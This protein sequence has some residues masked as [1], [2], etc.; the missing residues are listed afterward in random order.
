MAAVVTTWTSHGLSVNVLCTLCL[1]KFRVRIFKLQFHQEAYGVRLRYSCWCHIL[2]KRWINLAFKRYVFTSW[3][4][5]CE[6]LIWAICNFTIPAEAS[7]LKHLVFKSLP[8]QKLLLHAPRIQHCP[9]WF[10]RKAYVL[11]SEPTLVCWHAT[12]HWWA[13]RN[14]QIIVLHLSTVLQAPV[15]FPECQSCSTCAVFAWH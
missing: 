12:P 11:P 13:C 6:C 3:F 8:L 4:Q 5:F 10:N 14:M 15:Q 7:N 9:T 2:K 1:S